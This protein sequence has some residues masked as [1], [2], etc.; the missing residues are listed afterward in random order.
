MGWA[1]TFRTEDSQLYTDVITLR[2]ILWYSLIW[3]IKQLV[4][5]PQSH[6]HRLVLSSHF[7]KEIHLGSLGFL[8]QQ[9]EISGLPIW[10]NHN[11][12]VYFLTPL[13]IM[14]TTN[15]IRTTFYARIFTTITFAV[16]LYHV[17][18]FYTLEEA[19]LPSYM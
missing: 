11:S 7:N 2:F 9:G 4:P 10:R 14:F 16:L 12:H 19:L 17:H 15:Y 18:L 6:K 8:K 3:G 1:R 13:W 5:L